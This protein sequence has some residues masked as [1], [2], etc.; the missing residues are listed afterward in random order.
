[1]TLLPSDDLPESE[2]GSFKLSFALK[3]SEA[4]GIFR[5]GY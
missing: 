1:M 3:V 2:M 5:C 4:Y